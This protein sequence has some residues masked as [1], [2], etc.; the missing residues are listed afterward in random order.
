[1]GVLVG[2]VGLTLTP[3]AAQAADAPTIDADVKVG[4]VVDFSFPCDYSA[5][6]R[7]FS[8]GQLI[9]EPVINALTARP[10]DLGRRLMV[11]R[12]CAETGETLRTPETDIVTSTTTATDYTIT[13]TSKQLKVTVRK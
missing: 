11:E 9:T 2:L 12:T 3:L 10:E 8:G 6:D 13:K 7:W 5:P 4:Q 1:M